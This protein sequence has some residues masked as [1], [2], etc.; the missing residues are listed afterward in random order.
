MVR[1]TDLV[2]GAD[3]R[4]TPAEYPGRLESRRM[5]V[6]ADELISLAGAAP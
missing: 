3:A 5:L 6:S 2:L 1:W 4:L